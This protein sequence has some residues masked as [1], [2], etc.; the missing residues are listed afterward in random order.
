MITQA[1]LNNGPSVIAD[2]GKFELVAEQTGTK[3]LYAITYYNDNN[4][5]KTKYVEGIKEV[6]KA[7][8]RFNAV[9]A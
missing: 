3:G 2:S 7:A 1:Q 5:C 4:T 6:R 8:A 9:A